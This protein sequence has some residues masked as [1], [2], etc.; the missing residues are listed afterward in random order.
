MAPSLSR[1]REPSGSP[2]RVSVLVL[3]GLVLLTGLATSARADEA[4]PPASPAPPGEPAPAA[5]PGS[6]APPAPAPRDVGPVSVTATRAARPVLETPGHVTVL[7]REDLQA[8]GAAD[9]PDLLRREAGIYVTNSTTN[10]ANT[11]VEARGFNNGGGNGSNMLVLVDG[12]R[13]NETQNGIADWALIPIDDIEKVEIV[14]GAAS[15]VYGDNAEGGVIQIF[16]RRAEGPAEVSLQGR[17]GSRGTWDSSLFA[18]AKAGPVSASFFTDRGTTDGFRELAEFGTQLYHL[19]LHADLGERASAGLQMG[20][21]SD[22]R[23][24]PGAVTFSLAGGPATV[25]DVTNSNDV[26]TRYLSGSFEATP[27]DDLLLT[28]TPYTRAQQSHALSSQPGSF[29]FSADEQSDENGLNAQLQLD[30]G[31]LELRNRLILGLD[32]AREDADIDSTFSAT[33]FSSETSNH[34]RRSTLAGYL[35]DELWLTDALLLGAGVR[36]DSVAYRLAQTTDHVASPLARPE[37]SIWSPRV[38]LTYRVLEPLSAYVSYARGFRFPTLEETAQFAFLSGNPALRPQI[39]S[40]YETGVKWR[41]RRLRGDLVVYWM[42]VHDEILFDPSAGSFGENVNLDRTRHRGVE[43]G[44]GGQPVGWLD[45]SGSFTYDDAT[46]RR[47]SVTGFDG[48]RVP[49][50]PVYRWNANATLLGP[51]GLRA[52]L[53]VYWVGRRLFGNDLANQVPALPA[54]ARYD[55]VLRWHPDVPELLPAL[56]WGGLDLSF[57]IRNLT[58]RRYSEVGS[59]SAFSPGVVGVFPAAGRSYLVALRLTAKP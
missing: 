1:S 7:T 43:T 45:L 44:L 47:D 2:A 28:L 38:A 59:L 30:R 18:R 52:G 54:Y 36:Y 22:G 6:P 55:L 13:V 41:G 49:I 40:T 46:I 5:P 20:Y 12:R 17:A 15:A 26:R 8:S 16:T 35:Q 56:P 50:N 58:D 25:A 11:N 21:S 53:D 3:L 48:N 57:T 27:L 31:L 39:S 9:L 23:N 37:H 51:Y 33:G 34:N 42:D 32:W 29:D 14:R 24:L 10:P 19:D 4:P